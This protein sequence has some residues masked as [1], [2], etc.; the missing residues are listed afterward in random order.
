MKPVFFG[1][2]CWHDQKIGL[3]NIV[4]SGEK[5]VPDLLTLF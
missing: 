5:S 2:A 3:I 1:L 4:Q